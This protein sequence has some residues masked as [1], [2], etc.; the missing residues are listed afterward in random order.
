MHCWHSKCQW[1]YVFNKRQYDTQNTYSSL[2]THTQDNGRVTPSGTHDAQKLCWKYSPCKQCWAGSSPSSYI[3]ESK[4][5][6]DFSMTFHGVGLML[7]SIVIKVD[8]GGLSLVQSQHQWFGGRTCFFWST[9]L[10]NAVQGNPTHACRKSHSVQG[11]FLPNKCAKDSSVN[12]FNWVA[13]GSC[14]C[15]CPSVVPEARST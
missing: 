9:T 5:M 6:L 4:T 10:V 13:N 11:C 12:H 15:P 2:H 14:H 3:F 1:I 8:K 7:Q